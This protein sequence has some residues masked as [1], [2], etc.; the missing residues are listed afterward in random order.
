MS[1]LNEIAAT[2]N[3]IRI[4]PR[5]QIFDYGD[6]GDLLYI[7]LDG[8]IDV[9]LPFEKQKKDPSIQLNDKQRLSLNEREIR[10]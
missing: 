6:P 9:I 4:P 1:E 8:L 2:L 5:T 7:V 10:N 3:Y